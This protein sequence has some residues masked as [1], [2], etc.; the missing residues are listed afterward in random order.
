MAPDFTSVPRPAEDPLPPARA[1]EIVAVSF[2]P[3]G[4]TTAQAWLRRPE[5][6]IPHRHIRTDRADPNALAN[7]RNLVRNAKVGVR[8][9]FTGPQADIYAARAQAL[10]EGAVEEEITLLETDATGRQVYCPHCKATTPSRN[11]VGATVTCTGCTRELVI[12][13]HFSRRTASYLGFKTNAEEV[14]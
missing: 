3:A 2:S 8:F 13:H 4:A 6:G 12:Y 14:L 7:V 5:S 9:V 10:T 11:P 1:R